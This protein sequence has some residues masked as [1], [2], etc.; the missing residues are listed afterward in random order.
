[1]RTLVDNADLRARIAAITRG[2]QE[3]FRVHGADGYDLDGWMI[4][5]P[6]FD[7]TKKYPVLFHV[8]GEPAG[9]TVQDAWGGAQY[10][11]HLMLAQHGYIIASVDNRGTPPP[12]GRAWRKSIY[13]KIGRSNGSGTRDRDS[14]IRRRIAHRRVGLERRRFDD[15]ESPLPV[16]GRVS[17]GDVRRAG[18]R[19]ALLRHDLHRALHGTAAAERRGLS[20]GIA[21][22]LREWIA[23]RSPPRPR[24]RRRQWHYQNSET[25]VNALV[26]ANKPFQLMVYPNRTHCICERQGTTMHLYSLLTKYLEE[27]LRR[28]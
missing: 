27:H 2:P 16:A 17:H 21:G 1:V 18:D 20:S 28:E 6:G 22:D 23:W 15:A 14:S 12:R 8:Y 9:Q 19:S 5:P 3:F 4:K 11:W 25:L 24:L 26:S 10:L 13:R 7:S